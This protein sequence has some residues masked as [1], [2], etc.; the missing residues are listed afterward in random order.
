MSQ[1]G[2]LDRGGLNLRTIAVVGASTAGLAASGALRSAGFDGRLVILGDEGRTPYDRPPLSKQ[3]LA[4]DWDVDRL[5]LPG[6]ADASLELELE[7]DE[8][9]S[10]WTP[11]R[12]ASPST[13][14]RRSMP[15][16]W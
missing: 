9:R 2:H 1:A 6:T 15:T 10:P 3:F 12:A 7:P 11:P 8:P 16:A 13:T 4:G 14:G 5:S